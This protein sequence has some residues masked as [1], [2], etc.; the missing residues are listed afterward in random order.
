VPSQRRNTNPKGFNLVEEAEEGMELTEQGKPKTGK[1]KTRR[2]F[3]V[4]ENCLKK[5][6]RGMADYS[7]L[8]V[9]S[10]V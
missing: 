7:S 6:L 3:D 8:C 2:V 4:A 10:I 9:F 1:S 5:E